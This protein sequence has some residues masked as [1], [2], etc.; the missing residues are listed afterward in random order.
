MGEPLPYNSLELMG[1]GLARAGDKELGLVHASLQYVY[2]RCRLSEE[3]D[4][5]CTL[6]CKAC[7]RLAVR[8]DKQTLD[9]LHHCLFLFYVI[10]LT[11]KG[12]FNGRV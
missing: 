2:S 7:K 4:E 10:V 8:D 6:Y 12:I 9:M 3:R 11:Q 5:C 1:R